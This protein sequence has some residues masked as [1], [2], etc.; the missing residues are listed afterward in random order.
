[1]SHGKNCK[2]PWKG[3]VI[4]NTHVKYHSS[5]IQCSKIINTIKVSDR[6]TVIWNDRQLGQKQYASESSMSGGIKGHSEL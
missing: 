2:Y 6:I 5:S 3:I 1:M 4:R